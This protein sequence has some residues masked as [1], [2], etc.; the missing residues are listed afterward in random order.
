MTHALPIDPHLLLSPF[1][2]LPPTLGQT[3][4]GP[5]DGVCLLERGNFPF[6]SLVLFDWS[7]N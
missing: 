3:L 7:D 6:P 2:P 5:W 1:P 4:V